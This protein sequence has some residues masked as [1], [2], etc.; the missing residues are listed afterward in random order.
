M[1][2]DLGH[3][4]IEAG[5]AEI[6]LQVLSAEQGIDFV[7][8]D[9]AMPG[10]TGAE[11]AEQIHRHWPGIPVVLASGYPELPADAMGLPRLSKPYRQEE[12]ARLLASLVVGERSPVPEV[13]SSSLREQLAP[14]PAD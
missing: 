10:M 13:G 3:L 2:E 8:T 1:L 12:L 4:A 14:Q 5:S 6:A 7:I 9:Q 11:L